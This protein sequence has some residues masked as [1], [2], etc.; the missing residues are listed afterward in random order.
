MQ[1]AKNCAGSKNFIK[2]TKKAGAKNACFFD[3]VSLFFISPQN[4]TAVDQQ[5][6]RKNNDRDN[7]DI[8]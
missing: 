5:N 2:I 3:I 7:D 1:I 6:Y 4:L 8:L